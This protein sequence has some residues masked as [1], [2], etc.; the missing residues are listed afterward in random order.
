M[1]VS[2]VVI[3]LSVVAAA[4][5]I[6]AA[7]VGLFWQTEGTP[8][9]F[10]AL[11]GDAVDIY[12]RGIYADDSVF[13]SG[14]NRGGDVTTL[15]LATP[16]LV[17][18][19]LY[20]HR[21]SVRGAMV[22]LGA[23]T[24]FLYVYAS[25]ALG[26][27]YN[28]LFLVYVAIFGCSFYAWL[29]LLFALQPLKLRFAADLPYRRIGAFLLACGLLTS[30]VWIEPL[31]SALLAGHAPAL[32][33]HSTTMVTEALD[34]AMIAPACFVAGVFFL[35]R[36]LRGLLFAIP[37][38]ALLFFVGP[39]IAAMTVFQVMDGIS[40]TI[41][42]IVGPIGGF[43]VL[44]VINVWVAVVLLRAVPGQTAA[45]PTQGRRP[46]HTPA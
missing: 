21:G 29:L 19:L 12:A 42:Q 3:W 31:I 43:L 17:I 2:K 6:A 26:A 13:K 34:L 28:A 32:L 30:F 1:N 8:Y 11:N 41:P 39:S 38:V 18:A 40:F 23:L 35:R 37:V 14:A 16:V 27:A 44:G 4:L 46:V 22:L 15:F 20:Y 5:G 24:H 10:T 7:G 33:Y 25:L 9:T 45:T 36:D